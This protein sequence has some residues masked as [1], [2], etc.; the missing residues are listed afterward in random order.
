[1]HESSLVNKIGKKKNYEKNF[2]IQ[3]M[4]YCSAIL[5]KQIKL[6]KNKLYSA[7]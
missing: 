1:M 4:Q 3:Y 5:T 2:K 7:Q 6:T